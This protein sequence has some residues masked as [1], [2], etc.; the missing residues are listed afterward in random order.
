MSIKILGGVAKNF[1]LQ[2]INNSN[3]RPSLALLKRRVFDANQNLEGCEFIDLCAGTGSVG[4][5][6]WSRGANKVYMIEQNKDFYFLLKK[7]VEKIKIAFK[8]VYQNNQIKTIKSDCYKWCS[9]FI[10]EIDVN[11]KYIFFLDPP[12][13]KKNIYYSIIKLFE[14]KENNIELWIEGN[15]QKGMTSKELQ[16]L[17]MKKVKFYSQSSSYIAIIK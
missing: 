8:E 2:A 5:E 4:I 3:L 14:N 17:I 6:A 15:E 9:N 10:S 7:N 12:Y 16:S 1:T 11:K 13:E